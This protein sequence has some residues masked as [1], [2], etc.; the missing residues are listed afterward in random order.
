[1]VGWAKLQDVVFTRPKLQ[2]FLRTLIHG[3]CVVH[4]A[5]M[6]HPPQNLPVTFSLCL[7]RIVVV[8][9]RSGICLVAFAHLP[10]NLVDIQPLPSGIHDLFLQRMRGPAMGTAVNSGAFWYKPSRVDELSS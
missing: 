1:M 7:D 2:R 8:V 10:G 4:S 5:T 6:R 9:D 3:A